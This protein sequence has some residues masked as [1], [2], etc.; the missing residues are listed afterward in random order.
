MPKKDKNTPAYVAYILVS[1]SWYAAVIASILMIG[2]LIFRSADFV[3]PNY[4]A[5]SS[6]PVDPEIV[7][8][9]PDIDTSN[10]QLNTVTAKAG[11][12]EFMNNNPGHYT[13]IIIFLFIFLGTSLYG[14]YQ[15]KALLKSTVD[16]DV[17]NKINIR[18]L[19]IIAFLVMLID[20]V[21]WLV[22]LYIKSIFSDVAAANTISLS[23]GSL[24]LSYFMIGLLLL[25]L[26]TVFEKGYKMYQE[27]KLTV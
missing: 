23:L 5:Y 25:V 10:L 6:L 17:F 2:I 19:R 4:I 14:F 16:N 27:L 20:P 22:D 24:E 7:Q 3:S 18:R 15:L 9:K 13:G 11:M 26:S 8:F 12:A 1:I 21:H